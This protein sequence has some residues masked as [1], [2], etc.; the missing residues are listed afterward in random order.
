M[1]ASFSAPTDSRNP[2]RFGHQM[3]VYG[4]IRSSSSSVMRSTGSV[5]TRIF[6]SAEITEEGIDLEKEGL[7]VPSSTWTY[8]INDNPFGNRLAMLLVGNRHIGFAAGATLMQGPI[9]FV[10]AIYQWLCRKRKASQ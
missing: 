1:N 6:G 3:S 8:L 4:A 7:Q 5:Y 2:L 10:W 9:L